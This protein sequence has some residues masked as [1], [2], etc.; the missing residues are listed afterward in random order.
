V[1]PIKPFERF[2]TRLRSLSALMAI[3]VLATGSNACAQENALCV[4]TLNIHYANE[5]LA[6]ISAAIDDAAPTILCLQE[7]N[8][9]SE[10]YFRNTYARRFPYQHFAAH[11]GEYR[12][13]GLAI[14][15]KVPLTELRFDPPKAGL[16]GS[17]FASFKFDGMP[18]K[19]AN[20]HLSPFLFRR[21]SSLA[22]K[23][24]ALHSSEATH[25]REIQAILDEI[26]SNSP[27]LI[28]GDFNSLSW[29]IAPKR[30]VKAPFVD[31]FASVTQNAD[32]HATWRWP[33]NGAHLQAR[34]DYIFH[35]SHF[36]TTSSRIIKTNAS[37]HFLLV[38]TL[39]AR[40]DGR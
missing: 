19:I 32:M 24:Q 15:S 1:R 6:A 9:Q 35:S 31:S 16:F 23:Y 21:G 38:S 4:A 36:S 20:V 29:L 7:S 13:E 34:I 18:V 39:S 33:V 17:Y 11:R 26:N 12:E 3:L 14:L 30:L 27:T 25:E 5:D 28:C 40:H 8:R 10:R 37:D 2:D 22:E